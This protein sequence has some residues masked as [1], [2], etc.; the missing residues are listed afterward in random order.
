MTSVRYD[1]RCE[2]IDLLIK[3]IKDTAYLIN[4]ESVTGNKDNAAVYLDR[5]WHM[6]LSLTDINEKIAKT[7]H[8][9]QISFGQWLNTDDYVVH[10]M[11][12]LKNENKKRKSCGLQ[13]GYR[14]KTTINQ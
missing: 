2:P 10:M 9:N 11:K 8:Y 5:I 13:R 7:H 3:D 6:C 4:Y 1:G 14:K 12:Q